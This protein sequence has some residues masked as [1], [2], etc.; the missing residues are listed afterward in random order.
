[1]KRAGDDG[2]EPA[3]D[4]GERAWVAIRRLVEAYSVA[5][6]ERDFVAVATLFTV[7]GELVGPKASDGAPAFRKTG[8][9]AIRVAA[10]LVSGYAKTLHAI[11]AMRCQVVEPQATASSTCVSYH[12]MPDG[13]QS[14]HLVIYRDELVLEQRE[15]RFRR[16]VI[17]SLWRS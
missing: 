11:G 6:D 2:A 14:S 15:W 7:D 10:D 5:L 3:S 4:T 1:M 16:R 17:E 8:Q 12:L 9:A 13:S